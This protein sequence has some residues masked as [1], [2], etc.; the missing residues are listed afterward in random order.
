MQYQIV[1]GNYNAN[2]Y[3]TIAGIA[4]NLVINLL[5]IPS[6]GGI[7]AAIAT[8]VSYITVGTC[9]VLVDKTGQSK[10]FIIKMLHPGKALADIWQLHLA[11]RSSIEN[12]LS[13]IRQKSL[14]K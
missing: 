11:L 4:A 9:L 6:L 12:L 14:S 1:E 10:I 5:L 13:V 3:A 7:A 2:L 8:V